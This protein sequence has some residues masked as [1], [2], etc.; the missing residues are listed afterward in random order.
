MIEPL[1]LGHSP[2]EPFGVFAMEGLP[3]VL[4]VPQ[5]VL[6]AFGEVFDVGELIRVEFRHVLCL[7]CV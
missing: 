3:D 7:F 5:M 2:G 1:F 6:E 4:E